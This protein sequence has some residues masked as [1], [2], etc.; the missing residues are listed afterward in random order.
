[1][2][3]QY[4]EFGELTRAEQLELIEHVL[5]GGEIELFSITTWCSTEMGKSGV[6]C[7]YNDYCYRKLK[8]ELELLKEQRNALDIKIK[9]LEV[10]V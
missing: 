7:F 6:V 3:E 1:M 8:S 5:D 10:I 4:K 9:E 2:I